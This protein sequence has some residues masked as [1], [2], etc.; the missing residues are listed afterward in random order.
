MTISFQVDDAIRK[1][2]QGYANDTV[3]FATQHHHVDL[4]GTDN[5]IQLLEPMFAH[6]DEDRAR[7]APSIERIGEFSKMF[8]SY[9]GE[10]YRQNHGAQ[11][12]LVTW[13]GETF[14]GLKA[15]NGKIFWPWGRVQLRLTAGP[16]EN[17]WPYYQGLIGG[18][19]A[20]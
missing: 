8:G 12:G 19:A 7:E 2:A 6:L 20:Q 17:L 16:S 13:R 14:P 4:D 18:D 11:W 15:S 10:V 1:V 9:V 5:S 3:R